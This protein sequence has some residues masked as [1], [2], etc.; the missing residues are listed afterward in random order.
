MG[1]L[2][3]I[4]IS[5]RGELSELRKRRLPS[6]PPLVPARLRRTAE[7]PLRL[8]CEIK[9]RS[10]SAGE[11][12]RVLSV[13]ARAIS[14]EGAGAHMI[15]VLCDGPFFG[16]SFEDLAE[17]RRATQLPLL[18]KEFILDESQ[19]DAARAYGGSAALLIVRCLSPEE[20]T[21]LIRAAEERDLLPL[22]EITSVE[23][24]RV[25]LDAGATH[26]GVNA[27]DLDTL[28]MD[29]DRAR[30]IL[31]QLPLDIVA[32]HFSGVKTP[33]SVREL[34]RSRVDAAL[35]GE[36]LMRQDDPSALLGSFVQT[37]EAR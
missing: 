35:V 33:E 6:P 23:E 14:Y 34:A 31:E 22:V 25:A 4:L 8:I 19:L 12:S 30:L 37:A 1:V 16:G 2:E 5:K 28:K 7:D 29:L 27:R 11:L 10:P 26:L 18:C 24:A 36:I 9:R 3:Q 17:A 15:S 32:C 21:R 13:E 20:L